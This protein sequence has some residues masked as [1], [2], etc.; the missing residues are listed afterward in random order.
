MAFHAQPAAFLTA[1][2]DRLALHHRADVFESDRRLAHRHAILGR[3][4]IH[5]V[6]SRHR[7]HDRA[8]PVPIFHQMI[9]Q[10]HQHLIGVD[11]CA[12]AIHDGKPVGIRVQPEAECGFALLQP[13]EQL[14]H[15]FLDRL[16][17]TGAEERIQLTVQ[18]VHFPALLGQQHIQ[19]SATG[20]VHQIHHG[21]FRM[22]AQRPEIHELP[23][24]R[25]ILRHWIKNPHAVFCLLSSV[26]C[27][28]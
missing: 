22:L 28:L 15:V 4:G 1:N 20:P 11:E 7:P 25:E 2:D 12:V 14:A 23:Q 27:L 3:H 8:G 5:H 17:V 24:L 13:A 10:Q 18:R 26:F 16:R 9:K 6:T 21:L 19:I